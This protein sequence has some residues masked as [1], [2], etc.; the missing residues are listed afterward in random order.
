MDSIPFTR[1]KLFTFIYAF[2]ILSSIEAEDEVATAQRLGYVLEIAGEAELAD[3]VYEWLPHA[4][5]W[6]RSR[7][8]NRELQPVM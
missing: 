2:P 4:W 8:Q 1:S 6:S 5:I 7:H 3:V